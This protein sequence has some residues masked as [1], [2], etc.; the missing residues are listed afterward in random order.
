MDENRKYTRSRID[1][2]VKKDYLEDER[3]HIGQNQKAETEN[4]PAQARSKAENLENSTD[5]LVANSQIV[6]GVYLNEPGVVKRER[7]NIDGQTYWM[8]GTAQQRYMRGALL[9]YKLGKL[10]EYLP[11]EEQRHDFAGYALDW[12]ETYKV[13]TLRHTTLAQYKSILNRHLIPYFGEMD[14]KEIATA[15]IQDFLNQKVE[16]GYAQKSI[17]EYRRLLEM[18]LD[19]AVQD[20]YVRLNHAQDRRLRIG[21]RKKNERNYLT[22]E[23]YMDVIAHITDL[24]SPSDRRYLA[25]LL[26]TGMRRGEVLGLRWSDI[27]FQDN[28]IYIHNAITFDGNAPVEGPTKTEKGTRT[29]IM[30]EMLKQILLDNPEDSEFVVKDGVTSSYVKRMWER[31]KREIN[32]YNV[33]PHGIRHSWASHMNRL[34]INQKAIQTAG[35][36]ADEETMREIYTHSDHEDLRLATEMFDRSMQATTNQHESSQAG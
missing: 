2:G 12:L 16:E 5:S 4:R 23:Q 30:P 14:L 24:S 25:L 22:D 1:T 18:I 17:R 26:F 21:T 29:V 34:G 3:G 7:I 19:S 10:N 31:I 28:S 13:K 15:S 9:L 32:V 36:W 6:E 35:G 33:T 11:K 8:T 27:N 20:E